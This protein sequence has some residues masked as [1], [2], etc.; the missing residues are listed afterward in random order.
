MYA[1]E[2]AKKLS[3]SCKGRNFNEVVRKILLF[4]SG[5]YSGK[6]RTPQS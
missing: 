1:P 4:F 2:S 5:I 6:K 3:E